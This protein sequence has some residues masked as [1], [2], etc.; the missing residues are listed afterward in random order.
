MNEDLLSPNFGLDLV[1]AT[2]AS[3]IAAGRWMGLGRGE[4]ADQAAAKSMFED[5]DRLQIDG[6]VVVGEE[7]KM[8]QHSSLDSGRKVGTGRGPEVDVVVDPI[9]GRSLLAQG[10]PGAIAVAGMAPQGAMWSPG[11]AVY[12]EKLVV[13]SQV[14]EA[15]VP[16]CLDAPVAW[17]LALVARVKKKAVRD[18]VVFLLDRPR[19]QDLMDEIRTAGAR[20]MLR[21]DGDIAGALLAASSRHDGVD[22]LMGIGGV[23]EG[24]ISACA[25]KCLGGAM[26]VRLAPQSEPERDAVAAQRVDTGR[27]LTC[28]ELVHGTQI[29]F[30]ATGITDGPLLRGIRYHGREARTESIALRYQTRTRRILHAEHL[31]K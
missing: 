9:D 27:I 16:E 18:L 1:R 22:I 13:D 30:A 31:L 8:G 29:F 12:M 20:V 25:V 2:E 24:V 3:A 21:I 7:A 6:T 28:E 14:A 19:H 23:P 4:E 10:R 15:L 5:L 11:P 26:L 17:T